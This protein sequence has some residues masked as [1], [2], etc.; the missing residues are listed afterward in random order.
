M[1]LTKRS[2]EIWIYIPTVD[3]PPPPEGI[4]GSEILASDSM[5]PSQL[6]KTLK[7][8]AHFIPS[9]HNFILC[10]CAFRYIYSFTGQSIGLET[11]H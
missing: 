10:I 2:F 1:K 11:V 3:T 4:V 9:F 8:T 6:E 7:I 5:T